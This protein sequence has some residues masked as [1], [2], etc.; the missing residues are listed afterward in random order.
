MD[1]RTLSAVDERALT[2]SFS[3]VFSSELQPQAIS[4]EMRLGNQV[5]GESA[6]RECS[7]RGELGLEARGLLGELLELQRQHARLVRHRRESLLTPRA[8]YGR[9][10]LVLPTAIRQA[11][12][13]EER[14]A[15]ERP[16]QSSA[17]AQPVPGAPCLVP[18]YLSA[19]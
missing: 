16:V 11:R 18:L 17:G 12:L 9:I 5:V 15:H 14:P 7:Q 19:S 10:G 13:R 1:L 4:Q 8:T 2:S 3:R 6:R